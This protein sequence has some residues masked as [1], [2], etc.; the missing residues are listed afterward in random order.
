MI[1]K[2]LENKNNYATKHQKS[3]QTSPDRFGFVTLPQRPVRDALPSP[4]LRKRCPLCFGGTA[5]DPSFVNDII[6]CID[7]CFTQKHRQAPCDPPRAHPSTTFLSEEAVQSMEASVGKLRETRGRAPI[8]ISVDEDMVEPGMNVPPSVL[9]ECRDSFKA[10]DER[11]EKASTQF[12]ADTGL[13]ALL[14]RHD[15]VLWMVNMVTAGEKQHYALAL[16]HELLENLPTSMTVGV[17]YDIACQLHRSCLKWHFL[18]KELSRIT[19]STAVFHAY[20]H[21]WACQLIYHPRKSQGFGLSDGEGCERL[22]SDLKKVIPVLRVSGYHQRLFVL[23]SQVEFLQWWSLLKLG[24]WMARKWKI[25]T[26]REAKAKAFLVDQDLPRLRATWAEQVAAQMKPSLR[27][28]KKRGQLMVE[29]V[30]ALSRAVV[31]KE[32]EICKLEIELTSVTTDVLLLDQRLQASRAQLSTMKSSL[33][34][35]IAALGI[36]ETKQLKKLHSSPYL[37]CRMN[38]HRLRQCKFEIERIEHDH[39]KA[40]NEQ[41]LHKHISN[42]LNHREPAILSLV[43]QYNSLCDNMKT[44]IKDGNA[45]R[46]AAQPVKISQQGLFSVDVDDEIWQ[47]VGLEDDHDQGPQPPWLV[48]EEVKEGIKHVLELDRCEEEKS[49]LQRERSAMQSWT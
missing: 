28:A 30:L 42:A 8:P 40:I 34:N 19:F 26:T 43:S 38:A 37:H 3:V 33:S 5:H 1:K 25:C 18:G 6:V 9:N 11:R 13:M 10:A 21:N 44:Y 22:W 14:C 23:D 36:K 15:R 4:Y 20:A 27:Q 35:K 31:A 49:R 29:T 48:D 2:I 16:L 17:L 12:F 32:A 41:K 24:H 46:H 45:P 7:A 47:D 39:H